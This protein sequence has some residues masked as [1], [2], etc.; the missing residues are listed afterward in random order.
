VIERNCRN[1]DFGQSK[2]DFKVLCAIS[3][4]ERDVIARTDTLL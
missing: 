2:N 1:A 4:G 3:T